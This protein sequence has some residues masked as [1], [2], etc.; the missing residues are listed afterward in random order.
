MNKNSIFIFTNDNS[1]K[2]KKILDELSMVKE[3]YN[4]HV[5]DDS[6]ENKIIEDNIKLTEKNGNNTYLGKDQFKKFYYLNSD[7][8]KFPNEHIGTKNWNLGIARNFALDYSIIA[9]YEKILFVD[10]DIS[11]ITL[12]KLDLGFKTLTR[13][14]FVSCSLEGRTDDSIVDN[15]AKQLNVLDNQL[16]MLSGGFLF[17]YP[18]SIVHRFYNIYNED[19][20]LQLMEPNKKRVLLSF[21]VTHDELKQTLIKEDDIYFQ[22]IGEIIVDGLFADRNALKMG[23]NFWNNIINSRIKYIQKLTAK[24]DYL[25][26]VIEKRILLNLNEWLE[27]L[28]SNILLKTFNKNRHER[29]IYK[30]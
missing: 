9:N 17:L 5:I 6:N 1:Q 4:I 19:W 2:L 12:E 13:K 25:D 14:N 26:K 22:E 15:L 30:F 8:G 11:N 23:V 21:S 3:Y 20:I 10:D 16:R 18:K 29:T 24:A 27:K 7:T 28:T